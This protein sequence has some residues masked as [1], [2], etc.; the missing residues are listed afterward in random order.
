MGLRVDE[1]RGG[2]KEKVVEKGGSCGT[3]GAFD[4]FV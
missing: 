1:G 4:E 3:G 2:S